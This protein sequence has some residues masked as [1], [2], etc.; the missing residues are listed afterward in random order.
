MFTDELVIRRSGQEPLVLKMAVIH[1]AE[2]RA[3]E[4]ASITPGKAP[5]LMYLFNQAFSEIVEM[6]SK[7][8]YEY[9]IACR[10]SRE[11][12]AVIV[13]DKMPEKI[14]AKNL[15]NNAETRQAIIDLD[16]D[17]QQAKEQEIMLHSIKTLLEGKRRS[18]ENC[19]TAAKKVLGDSYHKTSL[20]GPEVFNDSGYFGKVKY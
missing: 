6:L 15:S 18:L 4:I 10:H 3:Q 1:N 14:K 19:Y 16:P 7:V 8:E 11:V 2:S 17:F 20:P 13:I 5:E 12:Q 9:E